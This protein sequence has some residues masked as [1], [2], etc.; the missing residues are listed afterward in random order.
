[1]PAEY[2]LL[3]VSGPD[4]PGIVAG[5]A[6][7]LFAAACNLEDLEPSARAIAQHM[8]ADG[9]DTVLLVPI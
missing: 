8:K 3:T 9:T 4:R 5:I 7:A 1:M 6:E 2:A